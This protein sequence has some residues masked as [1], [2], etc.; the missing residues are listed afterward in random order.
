MNVSNAAIFLELED[1][2]NRCDEELFE[3]ILKKNVNFDK[4]YVYT[5][6]EGRKKYSRT[7]K[8]YINSLIGMEGVQPS[9]S[10]DIVPIYKRM[11]IYL[12]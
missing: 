11:L 8:Q 4:D 2:V 10:I 5:S 3:N 7:I 6:G 12:L 1:A 9:K